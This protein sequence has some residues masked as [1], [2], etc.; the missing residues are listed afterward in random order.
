MVAHTFNS[1]TLK[2]RQTNLVDLKAIL[3]YIACSRL[4][5]QPRLYLSETLFQKEKRYLGNNH[6]DKKTKLSSA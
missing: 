4:G 1:S 3:V 5:N 6:E 2:Q